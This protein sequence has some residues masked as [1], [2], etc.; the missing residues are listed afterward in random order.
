M[1]KTQA[2]R[3]MY[4]DA[5]RILAGFLV[6]VNH[7]NSEV[8]RSVAPPQGTWYASMAWY[9]LCKIAVPLFVMLSGACLLHKVDSYR[10]TWTRIG[11]MVVAL[12]LFSALYAYDFWRS[13]GP[14][15]SPLAF[16]QGVLT[17]PVTDSFWYL[18]FY[19]GLL[20]LLPLLQRLARGMGKRD[21]QYLLAVC[22]SLTTLF[23]LLFR[24][25][26]DFMPS[27]YL[28]V[29]MFS[30][31]IAL[32]FAGYYVQ[33]F[34]TPKKWHIAPCLAVIVGSI[35]LS[36]FLTELEYG[37]VSAGAKYW[38]MDDRTLPALPV[39][40]CAFAVMLLFRA[41]FS[42]VASQGRSARAV[43]F[44]GGC[45]FGVYL[46]QDL[47]IELTRSVVFLPLADRLT[48]FPAVIVWEIV[49][50]ALCLLIAALLKQI[51]FLKKLL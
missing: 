2:T 14:W 26:P 18:Y 30:V 4:M 48:A 19:I 36:V 44:L 27:A 40:L 50:F 41:C 13:S 42:G 16:L 10:K 9:Y 33:A 17:T 11:R 34:T 45:A 47:V 35:V 6:I 3:H 39:V 8:F 15:P 51:P 31:W 43:I 37:R 20:L 29:S 5:L 49:V 12:A 25:F 38:F 21:V 22:L 1:Q 7:T 28:Q 24:Y 46:L 32:F 23:P